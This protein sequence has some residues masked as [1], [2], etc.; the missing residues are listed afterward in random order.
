MSISS[1]IFARGE[2]LAFTSAAIATMGA[3]PTWDAAMAK[4]L[5]ALTL[6]EAEIQYGGYGKATEELSLQRLSLETQHGKSWLSLPKAIRA[7]N[8][9]AEE[10][11]SVAWTEN[12][13]EPQWNAA[14]ALVGTPAPTLAAAVF[15]HTLIRR[16]ETPQW[17]DLPFDCMDV[18]AADFARLTNPSR[19]SD[20]W[21]TAWAAFEAARA[22]DEDFD[23][24]VWRPANDS[25]EAGGPAIPAYVNKEME[26]LMAARHE[27][28]NA[29]M[30]TPA[31][32]LAAA[33]WKLEYARERQ[34]GEELPHDWWQAVM[35]DLHRLAGQR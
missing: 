11:G 5:A 18:M 23:R 14:T 22:E 29:I 6:C 25:H 2:H 33:I 35:G 17:T 1:D 31:S 34:D 28:E 32:D 9:A 16:E 24:K 15:K 4:Y 12:F 13:A 8:D 19:P 10:A 21:A 27:A 7:E 30:A 20:V 26:R 3:C